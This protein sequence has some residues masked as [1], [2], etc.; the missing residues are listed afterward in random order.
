MTPWYTIQTVGWLV[1]RVL[2]MFADDS[3][4]VDGYTLGIKAGSQYDNNAVSVEN[5]SFA[6]QNRI[7]PNLIS[8]TNT[9][10]C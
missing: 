4:V 3:S 6:A 9:I 8:W 5:V 10:Q 2:Q 7:V 1:T